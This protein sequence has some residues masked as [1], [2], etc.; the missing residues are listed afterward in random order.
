MN[1]I[2]LGIFPP[3][4]QGPHPTTQRNVMEFATNKQN[5]Y[6]TG[7][8]Q[9][10]RGGCNWLEHYHYIQHSWWGWIFVWPWLNGGAAE[11][12]NVNVLSAPLGI[13]RILLRMEV[14]PH[15][16]PAAPPSVDSLPFP[17]SSNSKFDSNADT[18]RKENGNRYVN[19]HSEV[20]GRI[21][22]CIEELHIKI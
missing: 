7:T 5:D 17:L 13:H 10:L 18:I 3:D 2:D 19:I 11:W 16:H 12:R 20:V 1:G 4:T 15:H 22:V 8:L 9:N 21:R 14:G 6:Y